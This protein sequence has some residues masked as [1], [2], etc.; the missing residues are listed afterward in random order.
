MSR[1]IT[2]DVE[3]ISRKFN[4][5]SLKIAGK[6]F[7]LADKIPLPF[8]EV[9]ELA[10]KRVTVTLEPTGKMDKKG[11]EYEQIVAV[12]IAPSQ[13]QLPQGQVGVGLKIPVDST[14]SGPSS[15]GKPIP[16][17]TPPEYYRDMC[18]ILLECENEAKQLA[19]SFQGDVVEH[20]K[21]VRHYTALLFEKR[22][23]MSYYWQS[24]RELKK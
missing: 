8:P 23:P 16:I 13:Q 6:F 5:P 18:A 21:M 11:V 1:R 3:E 17:P 12:E 24:I 19:S 22:A 20:A 15:E 9:E 2:A 7:F 10:H 14:Y 4:S